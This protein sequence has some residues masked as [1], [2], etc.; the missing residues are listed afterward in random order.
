MADRRLDAPPK[1][2][3]GRMKEHN[4]THAARLKMRNNVALDCG[5][6]PAAAGHD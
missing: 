4:A 5:L 3:I 6:G 1:S 2:T